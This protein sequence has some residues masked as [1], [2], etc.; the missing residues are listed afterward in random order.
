MDVHDAWKYLVDSLAMKREMPIGN[1]IHGEIMM[2]GSVDRKVRILKIVKTQFGE[3]YII[4]S[5]SLD[6]IIN[7]LKSQGFKGNAWFDSGVWVID[8]YP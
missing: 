3:D 6:D 7:M 2:C 5:M 4:T 1:V 8:I